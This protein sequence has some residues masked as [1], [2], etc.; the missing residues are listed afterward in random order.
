MRGDAGIGAG[1]VQIEPFDRVPIQYQAGGDDQV[2]IIY[3][4]S[5]QRGDAAGVRVDLCGVIGNEVDAARQPVRGLADGI[6]RALQ[7]RRDKRETGLV[8]MF[9]APVDDGDLR[10]FQTCRKPVGNCRTA[11]ACAKDHDPGRGFDGL[12]R[13]CSPRW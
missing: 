9:S 11:R 1:H 8:P 3:P 2:I 10:A 7:A 13:G 4:L 5:A 12:C 6:I